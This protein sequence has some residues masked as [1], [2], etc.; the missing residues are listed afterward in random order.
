[1]TNRRLG[2]IFASSIDG[3]RIAYET[4]GT[5][6]PVVLL[7]GFTDS[8]RSWC[9]AGHVDAL[10]AG[11]RQAILID[12]RGHGDSGKPHDP[13]AYSSKHRV[14]DILAVLD[15]VGVGRANLI[16]YSMGGLIA[17]M[18]ALQTPGRVGALAVIGAHPFAQDMDPL[19]KA[20][21]GGI[22]GWIRLVESHGIQLSAA[23]R[24]RML[25]NDIAALRACIARDRSDSS[26]L[27]AEF[28]VPLLTVAGTRDPHFESVVRFAGMVRGRFMALEG[29]NHFSC[30]LAVAECI[31]TILD[32]FERN[33]QPSAAVVQ[34]Q[35]RNSV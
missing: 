18:T 16:G 26:G 2:T 34:R 27:L 17:L 15:Q 33:H 25:A 11:G 13:A 20:L 4:V 10:V 1:M 3:T 6:H 29:Q 8:R 12:C 7:H 9:E 35:E 32:H 24:E 19:R 31:P 14:A 5:G 23:V 28:R 21:S 30:F 22:E